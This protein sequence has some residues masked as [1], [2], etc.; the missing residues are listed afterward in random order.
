MC[1]FCNVSKEK[2]VYENEHFIG[3]FDGFPVTKGHS[4]LI[5]KRHVKTYFGLTSE[6]KMSLDDGIVWMKTYL[7]RKFSPDGYNIG[8]NNGVSAGQTILHLHLH[9]I[10]RYIGDVEN[11]KGGVRGVI[12]SKQSYNE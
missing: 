4:L 8:I 10:P 6:E 2:I 11:P 9:L 7:D 12:P 1:V 5:S 3:I